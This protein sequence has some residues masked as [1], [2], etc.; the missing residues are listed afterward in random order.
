L[1]ESR[2]RRVGIV[3]SALNTRDNK[4][5][6]VRKIDAKKYDI[7]DWQLKEL[8]RVNKLE[9]QR[10]VQSVFIFF[11]DGAIHQVMEML[12]DRSL[13]H[14]IPRIGIKK[15]YLPEEDIWQYLK[16]ISQA[17]QYLKEA[18]VPHLNLW[19]ANIFINGY[20]DLLV[21]DYGISQFW[22]RID[23]DKHGEKNTI[24]YTSPEVIANEPFGPSADIYSMGT[25]FYEL[26]TGVK[27]NEYQL[28]KKTEKGKKEKKSDI[29]E[30][31]EQ[32]Q[33]NRR[34]HYLKA[35]RNSKTLTQ[36]S[37]QFDSAPPVV[38]MKYSKKLKDLVLSMLNNNQKDRPTS[39]FIL[40]QTLPLAVKQPLMLGQ[41]VKRVTGLNLGQGKSNF[42]SSFR[43]LI[44]SPNIKGGPKQVEQ[45]SLLLEDQKKD[46]EKEKE[47]ESDK[48]EKNSDYTFS[49]F[50]KTQEAKFGKTNKKSSKPKKDE[51]TEA[52]FSEYFPIYDPKDERQVPE[53]IITQD[54][55]SG[56]VKPL[57]THRPKDGKK[58]TLY[59]DPKQS[60]STSSQ[61]K[62]IKGQGQKQKIIDSAIVSVNKLNKEDNHQMKKRW[63]GF[64]SLMAQPYE[65]TTKYKQY[66]QYLDSQGCINIERVGDKTNFPQVPLRN[67]VG[68]F[69][70]VS[71]GDEEETGED[72]PSFNVNNAVLVAK[73]Y[74]KRG[75]RVLYFFNPTPREY[76]KWLDWML[77]VVEENLI[78]YFTGGGASVPDKTG[79]EADGKAEAMV[80]Y[81]EGQKMTEKGL[82]PVAEKKKLPKI[83][84]VGPNYI[85]DYALHELIMSK[86]YNRKG[87]GTSNL[88]INLISDC[89]HS[90]TQYNFD[91][92]IEA[93]YRQGGDWGLPNVV[94]LGATLDEELNF[95]R[96]YEDGV[97]YSVFCYT[98][99]IF[100]ENN[101][102][103]TWN[104]L[105]KHL[106]KLMPEDQ[107][108]QL[109]G[110]SPDL[111]KN[112]VIRPLLA[113]ERE[114]Q[115]EDLSD[116]KLKAG[117]KGG[118][119]LETFSNLSGTEMQNLRRRWDEFVIKEFKSKRLPY[120]SK[121]ASRLHELDSLGMVPL[122]FVPR[123]QLPQFRIFP[124]LAGVFLCT[125]ENQENTLGDAPL[126][127]GRALGRI[128]LSH[129]YTV[130][131]MVDPTSRQYYQWLDWLLNHA[132][133]ELLL[134][135]NGH[136]GQT[137]DD[138]S[139]T[140]EDEKS[141]FYATSKIDIENPDIEAVA[142][143]I[144]GKSAQTEKKKQM[145]F[146][147]PIKGLH[148]WG[149]TDWCLNMLLMHTRYPNT[150]IVLISDTCNSGTMFNLDTTSK[151]A[152]DI[153]NIPNAIHIGA[154]RDGTSAQQ[155]GLVGGEIMGRLTRELY[156]MLG[157][158]KAATFNQFE[159][160]VKEGDIGK[161]QSVQITYTNEGL[162]N[163][164]ILAQ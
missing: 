158:N 4:I 86:N 29:K 14:R 64:A 61:L 136:G 12:E 56:T 145:K 71:D 94:H 121:N 132:D 113:S 130:L 24:A 160:R 23:I 38:E 138:L 31:K 8:A 66:L 88:R 104:D 119:T 115:I 144:G 108:V 107:H 90:G 140:E 124:K 155:S 6:A 131:Y 133:K 68:I 101:P 99:V 18:E 83:D 95:N 154:A 105:V 59:L 40:G 120:K 153:S 117:K 123:E 34:E 36:L 73:L 102:R 150:R 16:Q 48:S 157:Q 10:L 35:I 52:N 5:Y 84:G 146:I 161:S 98:M 39:D 45:S 139:G 147:S 55:G 7:Q 37:D 148:S 109:T 62:D 54:R 15:D 76:Y 58:Q 53:T 143:E 51:E 70:A 111:Y 3:Y 21:G 87:K 80:M 41:I 125:Y 69:F 9:N 142:K 89:N 74:L 1:D 128:L 44:N 63:G 25:I 156:T 28:D 82:D 42:G 122:K 96:E 141:E 151:S 85:L 110:T 106:N 114:I 13:L 27:P 162:K 118:V 78:V 129:G 91:F 65:Y 32:I 112:S 60:A 77:T 20:D 135:F 164:P 2:G 152:V 30:S 81:D 49:W 57:Q 159:T 26:C 97:N 50:P 67:V 11:K 19:P 46:H 72:V 33:Q 149:I 134:Y 43:Q 93:K 92:E 163:Q 17:L 137:K 127:D 79:R 126:N 103:A 47:K 116:H 22:L 75:Y 100:L